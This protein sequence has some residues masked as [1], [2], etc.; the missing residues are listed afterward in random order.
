MEIN[1]PADRALRKQLGPVNL[2]SICGKV[3]TGKSFLMNNLMER[4]VF[5]VSSEADSFTQGVNLSSHLM[6]PKAFS[7]SDCG[8]WV[9][10]SL[11]TGDLLVDQQARMVVWKTPPRQAVRGYIESVNEEQVTL[12]DVERVTIENPECG[13][14]KLGF[15]D[16]EGQ[17]DKGSKYDV[18]LATPLLLVSKVI[19]VN[20]LACAG[21]AREDVLGMLGIMMAAAKQIQ[22]PKR[23]ERSST[24]AGPPFGHLHIIL[25]DCQNSEQRCHELIFHT[26]DA[27]GKFQDEKDG[28]LARNEIRES[29]KSSFESVPQM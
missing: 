14:P 21:P 4:Y 18:K 24:E 12:G 22:P 1:E 29:I 25:R 19:L 10:T 27:E 20:V 23:G 28:I 13:T 8:K 6:C 26:E 16:M 15:V 2:I 7:K 3:R 9:E 5:G 11:S 17:S